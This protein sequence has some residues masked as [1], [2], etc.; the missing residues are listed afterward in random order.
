MSNFQQNNFDQ[1]FK[2][3]LQKFTITNPLQSFHVLHEEPIR[4]VPRQ[5]NIFDD[6][7]NAFL[8]KTEIV[9]TDHWRIHQIQSATCTVNVKSNLNKVH[10]TPLC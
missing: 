5:K 2:K 4:I 7:T 1:L 9:G 6:V 3:C 10:L 8:L